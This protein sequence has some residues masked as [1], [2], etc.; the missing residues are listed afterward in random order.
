MRLKVKT[1]RRIAL[2][3]ALLVM[4][5]FAF[6]DG[7]GPGAAQAADSAPQAS[8]ITVYVRPDFTIQ[9]GDQIKRFYDA[10]GAPVFPVVYQGTTYLP[11]RAISGLMGE[12][13]EW[14]GR[15]RTVFIGKTLSTPVK[16][17]MPP[18]PWVKDGDV[19]PDFRPPIQSAEARLRPDITILYD[20]A[21]QR[22]SDVNGNEVY[23]INYNG[24]VYLPIRAISR[25]MGETIEWD[26]AQKQIAISDSEAEEARRRMQET[27]D[28]RERIWLLKTAFSETLAVHDEATEKIAGL[29]EEDS[30]EQRTSLA[31]QISDDA[32]GASSIVARLNRMQTTDFTEEER[33][34]LEK[35]LAFAVASE[36]YVL[37][38]ENIAYLA[39]AGED[40]S[41]IADTFLDLA[42]DAQLK[43][44]IA[45]EAIDA[46]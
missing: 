21:V 31:I 9:V 41:M 35:L 45:E 8:A 7:R 4:L 16:T 10:T 32:R 29:Q 38:I 11:V 36:R 40:Y 46:L 6:A 1:N 39:A 42:L 17:E 25:L 19:S 30:A 18:S 26:E 28:W 44:E 14:D 5:S 27:E 15:S 23:P 34:A 12:N 3:A 22:F 2:L 13:I 20:F 33:D 43:K 37:I 24:S